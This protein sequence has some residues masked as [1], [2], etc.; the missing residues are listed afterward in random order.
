MTSPLPLLDGRMPL[1]TDPHYGPWYESW[2]FDLAVVIPAAILVLL[3]TRGLDRWVERTRPHSI[4]RSVSFFAGVATAV[5]AIE[6]PLDA[7]G[8]RHFTFHMI[9]H[10]ALTMVAAPLIL[11][12]APTTPLLRGLPRFIRRGAVAPLARSG[13]AHITY[14]LLVHPITAFVLSTAVVFAWHVV[15]GW[16]VAALRDEAL[17]IVQHASFALSAALGWWVV[18]DPRPLHARL[19]YP[20]R[21]AFLLAASTPKAFIAAYIAFADRP[22]FAEWYAT[23]PPAFEISLAQDQILAGM[24]MWLPSQLIYLLAMAATFF[25]WHAA[26]ESGDETA[27]TGERAIEAA[28][29]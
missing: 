14:R 19:T 26:A 12:G 27:P 8:E 23:V 4:W 5:L 15:P 3:Y 6:S 21:I 18:I 11:L 2:N 10:E 9:Q 1:H 13:W 25:V 7:L 22:L 28:P 17:H 29:R 20:A 16:Y 24:L